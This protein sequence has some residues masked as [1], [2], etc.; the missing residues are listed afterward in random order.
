M[1][2]NSLNNVDECEEDDCIHEIEVDAVYD[3]N[4]PDKPL[5]DRN[6]STKGNICD[7]HLKGSVPTFF[8]GKIWIDR[9]LKFKKIVKVKLKV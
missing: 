7:G 2:R 9:K 5:C 1:Y 6:M 3:I 8:Y 4:L